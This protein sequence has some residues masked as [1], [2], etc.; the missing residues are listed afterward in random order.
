MNVQLLERG[1]SYSRSFSENPLTHLL[2][3]CSGTLRHRYVPEFALVE[4]VPR[5]AT[6][7][8]CEPIILSR[9]LAR[10]RISRILVHRGSALLDS[11]K[12]YIY[13]LNTQEAIKSL[14]CENNL[15]KQY[16]FPR[17]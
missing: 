14:L 16:N 5:L 3:V 15:G 9:T 8:C 13:L 2:P 11:R 4:Y 1:I 12:T 6:C 10:S 7:Y 17:F